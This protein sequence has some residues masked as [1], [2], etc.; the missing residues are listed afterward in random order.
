MNP[1]GVHLPVVQRVHAEH[2]AAALVQ[3]AHNIARKTLRRNNLDC[4]NRLK[5]D[6]G[7]THHTLFK[8][9]DG[10][11]LKRHLRG[12]HIMVGTAGQCRLD[13]NYPPSDV[14]AK[15]CEENVKGA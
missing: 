5:K 13:T 2:P 7:S 8:C 6:W 14:Q 3:I 1:Q 11:S 9:L 12:I 10:S 15:V 4:G